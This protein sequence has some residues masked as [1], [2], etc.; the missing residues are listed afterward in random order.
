MPACS[1][2][3]THQTCRLQP[4]PGCVGMLHKPVQGC[5]TASQIAA[6]SCI[7]PKQ[8]AQY[9]T[10]MLSD[11]NVPGWMCVGLNDLAGL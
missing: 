10:S 3:L 1:R 6:N 2:V 8:V 9:V 7:W 11:I 5:N 4:V